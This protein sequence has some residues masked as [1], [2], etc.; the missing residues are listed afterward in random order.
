[1]YGFKFFFIW[2]GLMLVLMATIVF[3]VLG[4]VHNP[5]WFLGT[6]LA[7]LAS[8]W[9][10]LHSQR[11]NIRA[12]LNLCSYG[13]RPKTIEEFER[14]CR[15]GGYTVV[16]S[17]WASYLNR[18]AYRNCIF[19]SQLSGRVGDQPYTWETGA[20]IRQ[21]MTA[22]QKENKTLSR[23]PSQEWVTLGGWIGSMSHSHPGTEKFPPPIQEASVLNTTT[24]RVS[25]VESSTFFRLFEQEVRTNFV[26]S[27]TVNPIDDVAVERVA[28]P[29]AM[30]ADTRWWLNSDSVGR[31]ILPASEVR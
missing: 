21:I 11:I 16:G 1:M 18:K 24:G 13:R 19:T 26:L 25:T 10:R 4:F 28:R 23:F 20:S 9:S 7:I 22:L 2:L 31:L 8:V 17:G 30:D 14:L 27:V 12:T 3:T 29:L 15:E 6:L 5:W